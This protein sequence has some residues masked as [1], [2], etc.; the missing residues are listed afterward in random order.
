MP[1]SHLTIAMPT[2][3]SLLHLQ[4]LLCKPEFGIEASRRRLEFLFRQL[5]RAEPWLQQPH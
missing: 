1:R 2:F 3:L 4:E 5:P